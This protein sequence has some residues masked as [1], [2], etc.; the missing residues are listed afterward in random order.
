MTPDRPVH[1]DHA[2]PGHSAAPGGAHSHAD[3]HVTSLGTYFA[4]FAALMVLLAATVAVAFVNLG[5]FNAAVAM[6]IGATKAV[7]VALFFM[8]MKDSGRV[9]PLAFLA[10][11]AWLGILLGLI[12]PDYMTR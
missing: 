1:P 11:L 3:D 4:V 9:I 7:L 6:L 10:G 2:A 12:L 5:V 8:H